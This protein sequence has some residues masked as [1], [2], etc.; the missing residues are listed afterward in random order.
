MLTKRAAQKLPDGQAENPDEEKRKVDFD[1]IGAHERSFS[2]SNL[3][4]AIDGQD[5]DGTGPRLL[6]A[7]AIKL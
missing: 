6:M 7:A 2:S 1:A 4:P 5:T 3:I